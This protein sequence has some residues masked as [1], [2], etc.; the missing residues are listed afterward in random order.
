MQA[1]SS[2]LRQRVVN[3]YEQGHDSIATIAQR[4]SGGSRVRRARVMAGAIFAGL[5]AHRV[6]VVKDQECAA[7]R[8][9]ENSSRVE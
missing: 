3:A 8:Q 1:Y 5:F 6:D 2:D 9:S 4:F 7:G